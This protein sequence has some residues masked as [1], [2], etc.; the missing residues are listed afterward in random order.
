MK[1]RFC[2]LIIILQILFISCHTVDNPHR[3][4]GVELKTVLDK[5]DISLIENT[6][7]IITKNIDLNGAHL[8]IP[9]GCT[10]VFDGGEI[11]NGQ[12]QFD[13]T[14]VNGIPNF[15]N[16]GY[17]GRV[18]M[19]A[20]D[21]RCFNSQDETNTFIFL[22]RNAIEN[23]IRCDFYR[24]YK[25]SMKD[26]SDVYGLISFQDLN[27]GADI[28]FHGNTVYNINP[29]SSGAI[30]T[31]ITFRNV[32]NVTIRNCNFHD[33]DEH[34]CHNFKESAGC[35][36]IHCYGD[37]DGINLL[38]CSQRN[39]DCILRSGV[40]VHNE[41]RP[42]DTPR[43]GL[44][45][46]TIK[47][48]SD[49]VGYG[50]ALYCGDS[51]D[52][53]ITVN[54]PHR[55]F[56]CTGVSNSTIQYEGFNPQAT[57]TH[58]LIKDA[59]Y[60]RIDSTGI[61]VLDMKGCDHLDISVCINEVLSRESVVRFQSYG[62]GLKEGAD[63]RFRSEKC[64][65]HDIRVTANIR[66][67]PKK[68]YFHIC[69]FVRDSGAQDESDIIGCKV[70]GLVIHDIPNRRGTTGRYLLNLEPY[71]EVYAEIINCGI[72]DNQFEGKPYNIH[73][74]GNAKG[75][76]K[77]TNSHLG[78]VLIREKDKGRF[79]VSVDDVSVINNGLN[80]IEDGS[81]RSLVNMNG[82]SNN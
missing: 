45:N 5:D 34:D 9:R 18:I 32:K 3:I 35:T 42:E 64:H 25:I 74:R 78:G 77:I 53:D 56:Y 68:G 70:S 55:G 57:N 50:L 36:F 44:I 1:G 8:S 63:F 82:K 58:I 2:M 21:D 6:T 11:S 27:S 60:R 71:S 37:C 17:K 38:D 31:V 48:S 19:D 52:L 41:N 15:S 75:S 33:V 46:S 10:L 23:G 43:R 73:V 62:T 51:L 72:N 67:S 81:K 39:G 16:C 49:N 54:N 69:D 76:L 40:W 61:D 28:N 47:V 30:K 22:L 14:F 29:F 12:I 4:K 26:A 20:I 59:V 24:D 65:H 13:S 66:R 80:F 79:D 7:Y